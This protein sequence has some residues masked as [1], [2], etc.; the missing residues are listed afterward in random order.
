L[1]DSIT[2][3][4]L[5]PPPPTC[6]YVE[7][8]NRCNLKCVTC[9]RTFETREEAKDL[10]FEEFRSAVDQL[11]GLERAVLHGIGEPLLNRELPPMIEYLKARGVYVL[12]NSN[13]TLLTPDWQERLMETGLDEFRVSMD[14][15]T[16][17]KYEEVR[18]MPML[19]KLVANLKEFSELKRRLG[20]PV[21]K[22]SLWLVGLKENL[23]EMPDFFAI[24]R[25]VGADEVYLQRLVYADNGP[26]G[27]LMS[28]EH[29][30]QHH[31]ASEVDEVLRVCEELSLKHGVAL[32]ASGATSPRESLGDDK[33]L[34]P[35]KACQRPFS[36]MY[37][38]ANGNILPCCIAPFAVALHEYPE[39]ILGNVREKSLQ[40]I[41][42][43]QPYQ[44]WRRRIL[45]PDPATPCKSC[46]VEWSL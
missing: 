3:D 15:A 46:G 26:D 38:T 17:E 18:G 36:L 43:G 4:E 45:S 16:E 41:W 42:H 30:L 12:F 37:M 27:S 40:E 31:E 1:S 25:E 11:P 9:I 13:A 32:K 8:T 6:L 22:V 24:A 19:G 34:H 23:H 2:K 44:D 39:I 35:W 5:F 14:A 28:R 10:S 29:S 33:G 20:S 21:P 7:V